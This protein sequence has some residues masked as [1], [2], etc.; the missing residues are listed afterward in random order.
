M[1]RG[2]SADQWIFCA[3]LLVFVPIGIYLACIWNEDIFEED[4][5]QMAKDAQEYLATHENS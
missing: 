2:V 3:G 5:E 4:K 1:E